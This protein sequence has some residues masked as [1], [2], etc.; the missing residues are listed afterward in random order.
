[1]PTTLVWIRDDL[2]VTDNPALSWAAS[3]GE[4]AGVLID[5]TSGY[6][7]PMVGV[8]ESR[9]TALE[10]YNNIKGDR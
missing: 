4:V 9:K 3:R 2:R 7:E 8:N 10:T 5:D 6:P 1:M